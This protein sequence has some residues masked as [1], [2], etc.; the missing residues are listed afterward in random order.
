M[1]NCS[2]EE[3]GNLKLHVF[4]LPIMPVLTS[5]VLLENLGT[6][7]NASE[8]QL[9]GVGTKYLPI[10]PTRRWAL[11]RQQPCMFHS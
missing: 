8:R 7:Q 4:S 5:K 11:R 2:V 6:H 1:W 9:Q 10:L 3:V